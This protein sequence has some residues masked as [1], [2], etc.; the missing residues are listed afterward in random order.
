MAE[1]LRDLLT[2][3]AANPGWAQLGVFLV[4][5]TESLA[6]VGLMVPGAIMMVGAGA[7]IAAGALDF[8]PVCLWAIAGA[9]VGDGLSYWLGRHYRERLTGLWPFTRYPDSL[10]GGVR[11]FEKYG[12]KS[13]AF[14]RFVGPVRAVIPLVAGMLGMPVGRFLVANILSAIAWAP[15]Y[16]LPGIVFGASLEL[17]AEAAFRLVLLLLALA[18]AV[19]AVAWGIRQ[20]FLLY[21]PRA[22]GWIEGLLRRAEFHPRMGELARALADPGHPDAAALT[23]LAGVLLLTTLLFALVIGL[24]VAGAP[25]LPLNRT[26]LHLALSLQTPPANQLMAGCGRLGDPAVILPLVLVVY[27]WLYRRGEQRHA[28]YWLAAGTFALFAGPLLRIPGPDL[29]SNGLGSDGL[30]SWAFPSGHTLRATVVYGFL[31][32]VLAGGM[33]PTWR[34]LPYAWAG[35]LITLVGSSQLYF[36]AHW[37]TDV[38]VSLTLGLAWVATLG[39]AYRHHRRSETAWRRLGIIALGTLVVAFGLHSILS[40][41]PDPVLHHRSPAATAITEAAWRTKVWRILPQT[42][43]DLRKTGHYPLNL[44]YA[45]RLA[46]LRAQL[47]PKG[48]EP[49]PGLGWGT[50]IKLLSPA[51]PLA[52][53]PVIPHVHQGHHEALTLVKQ[54]PDKDRLVLRLWPTGYRIDGKTPLWIGNVTAQHRRVI[55]DLLAVPTT[56]TDTQGPLD[57]VRKDL[58][59]LC[60]FRPDRTAPLLLQIPPDLGSLNFSRK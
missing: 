37:L 47:A 12:G 43:D 13:V 57:S 39:L 56:D 41:G 20:V 52:Q 28:N 38:L 6:I 11:F 26:V 50:A 51:L 34:W 33:T 42:R 1:L 40:Q 9:V 5:L 3:V 7:L 30:P 55:L 16:L 59:A 24:V 22:K 36:G 32:V 15:A 53:L 58:S 46:D 4:A 23:A 27:G 14:G 19:W 49:G 31:A 21:S 8:W 44:Q 29:G 25:D 35:T 60:P 2:W 45:G 17:A 18:V 48:W 54:G 10:T